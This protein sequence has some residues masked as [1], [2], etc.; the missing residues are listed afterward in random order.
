[1]HIMAAED[2]V[3]MRIS[4]VGTLFFM[5][6]GEVPEVTGNVNVDAVAVELVVPTDVG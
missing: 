5:L 3:A 1:M 2:A 6:I 4:V